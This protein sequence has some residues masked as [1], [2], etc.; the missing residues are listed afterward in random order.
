MFFGPTREH[1]EVAWHVC[2]R[3]IVVTASLDQGEFRHLMPDL[4]L[5][6]QSSSDKGETM[7]VSVDSTD[8]FVTSTLA[9]HC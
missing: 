9:V 3:S 8:K 5:W 2:Q 7:L 6:M 4:H 1:S